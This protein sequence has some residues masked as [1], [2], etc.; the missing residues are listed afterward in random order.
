M[1]SRDR[2]SLA[3]TGTASAARTWISQR[4]DAPKWSRS[5]TRQRMGLVLLGRVATMRR[6]H[7][8]C[9]AVLSPMPNFPRSSAA[10][11]STSDPNLS[12]SFK[13]SG[14]MPLPLSAMR[15]HGSPSLKRAVI[16]TSVASAEMQ[17]SMRSATA[18]L[19]SCPVSRSVSES[20]RAEG[21]TSLTSPSPRELMQPLGSVSA[22]RSP[23]K[24]C[25]RRLP[26]NHRTSVIEADRRSARGR[27]ARC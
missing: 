23:P 7:C 26:G 4:F 21:T 16:F 18:V 19:K 3:R 10:Y 13:T 25:S 15:I 11:C 14:F 27:Q 24:T 22:G 17:L 1:R 6:L 2:G 20:R 9:D 12:A 8:E 5:C